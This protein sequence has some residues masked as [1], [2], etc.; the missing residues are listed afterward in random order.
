VVSAT[1]DPVC[2]AVTAV[3]PT[4]TKRLMRQPSVLEAAVQQQLGIRIAL[5]SHILGAPPAAAYV[6]AVESLLLQPSDTHDLCL[7]VNRLRLSTH[8]PVEIHV[9]APGYGSTAGQSIWDCRRCGLKSIELS[10]GGDALVAHVP[11][12]AASKATNGGVVLP[13]HPFP[14]AVE[15]IATALETLQRYR[16]RLGVQSIETHGPAATA[17][18]VQ[19]GC[20]VGRALL[21]LART[22]ALDDYAIGNVRLV[23]LGRSHAPP[24]QWTADNVV[25]LGAQ[26]EPWLCWYPFARWF[27][28]SFACG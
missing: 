17:T 3:A 9:F 28:F 10:V 18:A 5:T 22:R 23:V 14:K 11:L 19:E 20:C 6:D 4:S 16:A 7:P 15:T 13:R 1:R 2:R 27:S 24:V 26:G 8:V 25:T 21:Q 12:A